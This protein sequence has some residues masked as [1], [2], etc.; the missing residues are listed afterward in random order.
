MPF[1]SPEQQVWMAINM[2]DL[3]KK[4]I[5]KYGS[6]PEFKSYIRKMKRRKSKID[7]KPS[8][9]RKHR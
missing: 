5:A 9:R 6:H 1:L 4:W 2:P 8:T 7:K 3:Y